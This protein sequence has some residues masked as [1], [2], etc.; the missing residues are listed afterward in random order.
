MNI[1]VA[2]HHCHF[3]H[4]LFAYGLHLGRVIQILGVLDAL[5]QNIPVLAP[6]FHPAHSRRMERTAPRN[7]LNIIHVPR[8]KPKPSVNKI[9]TCCL[10]KEDQKFLNRNRSIVFM[11]RLRLD[12]EITPSKLRIDRTAYTVC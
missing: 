9:E 12:N 11:L 5:I 3:L 7:D 8:T 1:V 2:Y 4:H 6:I 10:R